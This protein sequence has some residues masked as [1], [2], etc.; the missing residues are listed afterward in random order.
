[1]LYKSSYILVIS[2]P[3]Q[4][5]IKGISPEIIHSI[6]IKTVIILQGY[7]YGEIT[8]QQ[9]ANPQLFRKALLPGD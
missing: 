4:A 8:S 7:L 1:M 5:P 9:S 3:T 2:P 6:G